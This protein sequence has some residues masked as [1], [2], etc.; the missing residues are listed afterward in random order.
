MC[1]HFK[2]G[3]E[4]KYDEK[5]SRKKKQERRGISPL[6][7]NRFFRFPPRPKT[8][9]HMFNVPLTYEYER[10]GCFCIVNI[11]IC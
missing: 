4:Q 1:F 10:V 11:L 9:T 6:A 7:T 5:E 2:K 8:Y 3:Y